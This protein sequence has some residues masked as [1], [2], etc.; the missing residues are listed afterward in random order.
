MRFR[1]AVRLALGHSVGCGDVFAPCVIMQWTSAIA[2]YATLIY[3]CSTI[4]LAISL[5]FATYW[6]RLPPAGATA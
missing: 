6:H 3:V 5:V 4:S 1:L 2:L